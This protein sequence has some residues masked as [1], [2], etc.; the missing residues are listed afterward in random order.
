MGVKMNSQNEQTELEM[1]RLLISKLSDENNRLMVENEQ[2]RSLVQ[3]SSQNVPKKYLYNCR[4]DGCGWGPAES[5]ART[6]HERSVH[7][8]PFPKPEKPSGSEVSMD[9]SE[10]LHSS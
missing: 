8:K 9:N 2:L 10:P 4:Y 7:G 3:S 6:K 1:A 5:S